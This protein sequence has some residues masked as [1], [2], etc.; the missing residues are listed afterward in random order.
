VRLKALLS[1]DSVC[2]CAT[3]WLARKPRFL[4]LT[5]V[6][7]WIGPRLFDLLLRRFVLVRASSPDLL[8]VYE[9]L[10]AGDSTLYRSEGEYISSGNT[11]IIRARVI[12]FD[13]GSRAARY[14]GGFGAGAALLACGES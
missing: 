9:A 14:W 3:R 12:K 11:L 5:G 1:P 10:V 7:R 2:V 13:P 4:Q 8:N 6:S